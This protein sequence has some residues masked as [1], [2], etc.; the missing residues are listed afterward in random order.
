MVAVK[1]GAR[2]HHIRPGFRARR[3][4]GAVGEMDEPGG[5][6]ERAQPFN[7][8]V[9]AFFLIAGLRSDG[10]GEHLRRGKVS[11]NTLK[12][13]APA[14]FVLAGEAVDI[15]RRDAEPIHAGI[16]F[17]VNANR[18]LAELA[19][20]CGGFERGKLFAAD[21]GRR[22]CVSKELVFLTGPEAGEGQ[23][24]FPNARFA[25][26]FAFGG[27]GDAKPVGAGFFE[28]LGHLRTAVAVSV[29]LDDR[30][31]FAGSGAIFGFRIYEV[32]DGVEIAGERGERNFGPDRT[33][34]YCVNPFAG[35]SFC[36]HSTFPKLL[37]YGIPRNASESRCARCEKDNRGR[38]RR[39]PANE[40]RFLLKSKQLAVAPAVAVV[41]DRTQRCRIDTRGA[42]GPTSA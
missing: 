26:G 37:F 20:R 7:R 11:K 10:P 14:F 29:A 5:D 35:G 1:N 12:F 27:A 3:D 41:C 8:S 6:A 30:E 25:H 23:D 17:Q 42:R 22:N 21:H 2:T 19:A 18:A 9:K 40:I 16:N 31:N 24:G 4:G 28:R 32:A 15:G 34:D 36:R 13:E 39:W 33:A 38:A